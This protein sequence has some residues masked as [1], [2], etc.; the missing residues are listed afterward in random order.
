[1][2]DIT[3]K[4]RLSFYDSWVAYSLALI[5]YVFASAML[6]AGGTYCP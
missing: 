3:Y 1:M 4:T 2:I 5:V 6:V